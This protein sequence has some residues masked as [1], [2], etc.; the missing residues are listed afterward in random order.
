MQPVTSLQDRAEA[1]LAFVRAVID[2]SAHFTAVPGAGGMLMGASALLACAVTWRWPPVA[3]ATSASWRWLWFWI[4]EG[5]LAAT[6]ALVAMQRKAKRTGMSL[7]GAP[8]RRFAFALAPALLMGGVLTAAFATRE[9]WTHIA[10]TWLMCYGVGVLGAATVSA[11]P[12]VRAL[13]AGCLSV[14]I[15]AL[16]LP[17]VRAEWWLA[18]AFGVGHLVAGWRIRQHHGG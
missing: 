5:V 8:A 2:R 9:Q 4:A 17:S 16:A 13:G 11:V 15:V 14:G 1:D 7:D 6:I 18:A 12:I 3:S 10:P